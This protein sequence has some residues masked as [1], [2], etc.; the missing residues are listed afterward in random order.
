MTAWSAKVSTSL[1]CFALNGRT[2]ARLSTSRL[3]VFKRVRPRGNASRL[4]SAA[5]S[6]SGFEKKSQMVR[7]DFSRAVPETFAMV[8]G[9]GWSKVAP[10]RSAPDAGQRGALLPI[11]QP[12]GIA[13]ADDRWISAGWRAVGRGKAPWP[14]RGALPVTAVPDEDAR[15]TRASGKEDLSRFPS[16]V[17]LWVVIKELRKLV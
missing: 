13:I 6:L 4:P 3:V 7:R 17:C 12:K 16:G 9:S 2:A 15:A 5:K 14:R 8:G 10:R 1:I 11:L